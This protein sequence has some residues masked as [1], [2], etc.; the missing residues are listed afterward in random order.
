MTITDLFLAA[1]L[2]IIAYFIWQHSNV[3]HTARNAAKQYCDKEGVQLLDQTVILKGISLRRSSR[4]LFTLR[5]QYGFEF[6]SVGDH[7][8]KGSVYLYGSRVQ[9]VELEPFKIER[10]E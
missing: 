10:M 7:R 1:P 4:S 3:S 8:Y 6:S 2:A 5:R 9:G